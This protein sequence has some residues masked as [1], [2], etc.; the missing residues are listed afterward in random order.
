MASMSQRTWTERLA[1]SER[2]VLPQHRG[3]SWPTIARRQLDAHSRAGD[4]PRSRGSTVKPTSLPASAV[5][6][7][8]VPQGFRITKLAENLS[9]PRMIAIGASGA[10]YVTRREQGDVL[11]LPIDGKGG[12]GE[13]VRVASRSGMHAI[14]FHGSKVYLATPNEVYVADVLPDGRAGRDV[15]AP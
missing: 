2:V 7:L 11:M 5:G 10:V 15:Q 13:P 3:L 8:H 14:A 1:C 6:A 12:V 4:A 9:N